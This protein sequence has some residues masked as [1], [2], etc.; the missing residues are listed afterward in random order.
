MAPVK[1]AYTTYVDKEYILFSNYN[2][3]IY[4]FIDTV[5]NT[6]KMFK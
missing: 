1:Y 6:L 3:N 2:E 5:I 4:Q